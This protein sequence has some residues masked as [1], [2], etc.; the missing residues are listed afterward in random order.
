MAALIVSAILLSVVGLQFTEVAEA[1]PDPSATILLSEHPTIKIL[2]PLNDSFF[3]VSLGGVSFQLIYETNSTLSWV[4]YTIGGTGHSIEDRGSGNVPVSGNGT[5]VHD[6]GNSGYHTL[7]LN[8]YDT[9]GNWATPQTITYLVNVY[10]DS[11]PISSTSPTPE[12]SP[13]VPEFQTWILLP[14]MAAVA[15]TIV[16]FKRRKL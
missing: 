8:A 10:P 6:M 13:S 2:Y 4:S 1:I 5:W 3:N 11:T 14:I 12:P 15:T 16:C 7:T 9:S